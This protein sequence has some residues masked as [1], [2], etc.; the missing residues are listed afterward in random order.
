MGV[1]GVRRRGNDYD[2]D[3][4]DVLSVFD[5]QEFN[6]TSDTDIPGTFYVGYREHSISGGIS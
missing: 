5:D 4:G 6:F 1:L 3:T 2:P